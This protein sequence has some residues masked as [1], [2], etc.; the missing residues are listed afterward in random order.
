[1][2]RALVPRLQ[3]EEGDAGILALA[4]E[5]EAADGEHALDVLP[6]F[7]VEILARVIE[8]LVG[9]RQGRAGRVRATR[10]K[11]APVSSSG[12]KPVGKRQKQ[13]AM[14]ATMTP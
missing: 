3:R 1:M 10:V 8:R 13:K 9:P 5:G 6:S 2:P 11:T 14:T 12:M 7:F 4:G